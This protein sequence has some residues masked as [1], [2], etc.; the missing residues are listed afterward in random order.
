M[1]LYIDMASG[2]DA[3]DVVAGASKRTVKIEYPL[4]VEYC[5]VCTLPPEVTSL[6]YGTT[7]TMSCISRI[8]HD[9]HTL[10]E[11]VTVFTVL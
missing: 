3:E 8:M 11:T 4:H 9:G 1:H 2:G 5:G 10:N 6:Q 7:S